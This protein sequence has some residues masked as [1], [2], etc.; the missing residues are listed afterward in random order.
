MQPPI[1]ARPA[2]PGRRARPALPSRGPSA[3]HG[4]DVHGRPAAAAPSRGSPSRA[5]PPRPLRTPSG[6]WRSLSLR[7]W[8]GL[9]PSERGGD[10][11]L[12]GPRL[13][14]IAAKAGDADDLR[15][16]RGDRHLRPDRRPRARPLRRRQARGRRRS[17][18]SRRCCS[19]RR[20]PSRTRP[21]GR[22]PASTQWRS[23]RPAWTPSGA[24]AAAPPPSPS[25]WSA[26][27]SCRPSS[28]RTRADRR[29][30]A[31]GDHPVHPRDPGISRRGGQEGDH[32]R[33]PQPELLRQPALRHQGRRRRLLRR[34]AGGP[35]PG[36]GRHPRRATRSRRPTTTWSATP[37]SAVRWRSPKARNART[38]KGELV[39][40]ADTDHRPA[41]Q[42]VLDFLAAGPDADLGTQYSRRRL[43]AAKD[44]EVV[45]ASQATPRWVAPHFVWA[46]RDELTRATV[47]PD[48]ETC[49]A[50]E[51]GGLRVTT[52]LDPDSRSSPRSGS[53]GRPRAP[54]AGTR[55]PR[56]G[57]SASTTGAWMANLRDKD[58]R[59]GAL[60]AL[61]YQTGELVA[62]VGSA[63]YYSTSSRPAF[64]P[65]FDVIGQ[66]YRQPGSAFKPFNYA[67][68]I[69]DRR[70][71][72][73]RCSWT[74]AP[75]SA[76]TT[77]RTTP[78]TWSAGRCASATPSSSRSTSPSSRRWP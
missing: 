17:R 11:G 2:P 58:L 69:D 77:P 65:Q 52:T 44:E 27:G 51:R 22:T 66:G 31:Q 18:R 49:D 26:S 23:W 30:E 55:R 28:S 40:P 38:G 39:V 34:R 19:T 6:T 43:P 36:P 59:N 60:V 53:G 76:A 8:P 48:A 20:P 16:A 13:G 25:S 68:G 56:P 62:Y 1:A 63:S 10:R 15:P 41:P 32:H 72:R 67:V 29:A 57:R 71:P 33:L 4:T 73:R 54:R 45:L 35:D 7:S 46:V 9:G 75:T 47:R 42:R 21:S 14:P 3:R 78:T 24:T 37:P 64:Q 74:S 50:L 5:S 12:H 61:D 70:S